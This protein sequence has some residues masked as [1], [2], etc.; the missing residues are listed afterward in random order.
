MRSIVGSV[1]VFLVIVGLDGCFTAPVYPVTPQIS[2]IDL[3]F[4]KGTKA[5]FDSI[6]LVINFKDGD[7]D[8]GLTSD[9]TLT[10]VYATK[11]YYLF[12]NKLLNYRAKLAN[13][14]LTVNG[15]KLPDFVDPYNCSNWEIR[16]KTING[17]L[18]NVDTV[19][20]ELNDNTYNIFVD[21]YIDDGTNNFTKFDPITYFKYPN[22]S[23]LSFNGRFPVLSS[24]LGKKL[25]LD[26][27]LT[28]FMKSSSFDVIIGAKRFYL[29]IAIQDRAL[30]K[31]NKLTTDIVTLNSI[32][33]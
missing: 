6:K 3:K 7:G 20:F 26:G 16:R 10:D 1:L 8:L 9:D 29:E 28:Y 21:Y 19:Y 32:R 25:P 27:I 2:L 12:Q 33:E 17:V 13:P 23:S 18:T 31:S 15:K 22:C 11:Y 14:N 4:G 24:D 5:L 30:N